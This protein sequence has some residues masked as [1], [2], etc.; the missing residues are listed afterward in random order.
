MRKKEEYLFANCG[1][2]K[3][4]QPKVDSSHAFSSLSSDIAGTDAPVQDQIRMG[5]S[6]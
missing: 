4:I 3:S 6:V 1:P 5:D 2:S